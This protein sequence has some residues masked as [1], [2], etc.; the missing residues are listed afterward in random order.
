MGQSD[1]CRVTDAHAFPLLLLPALP[2]SVRR[3]DQG[4]GAF[5]GVQ[6]TD[7]L[8]TVRNTLTKPYQQLR[9]KL[10]LSYAGVTVLALLTVEVLL[11]LIAGIGVTVLLN[12][13]AIPRQLIQ[14]VSVQYT[15]SLRPHL[16][17]SPPDLRGI[18]DVL[19]RADAATTITIPLSF[20]IREF[21]VIGADQSLL[22]SSPPDL[23]GENSLGR[24]LEI[25]TVP[26]LADPLEAALAGGENL[27]KLYAV[28][29]PGGTVVIAVPVWDAEHFEVLGALVGLAEIPTAL[30]FLGEAA[31]VVGVSLIFFTAVAGVAG[32]AYGLLA[33]RGPVERLSRLAKAS[34]AWGQG[35]FSVVVEDPAS[36]ELGELARRL[37]QMAN[38]LQQLLDMRQE[39]AA[40]RERNRLARD[41]HD[42]VKQLAFATAAQIG[43]ARTLVRRDP[44]EAT[45]HIEE[46]ERLTHEL[47]QELSSL[48]LELAP[49]ALEDKGLA[50]ALRNYSESWSRQN[51]IEVEMRVQGERALPLKIDQTVFRIAQE[52][53]ANAARHSNAHNMEI[54][55]IYGTD[56]IRCVIEDDGVGFNLSDDHDG[57]GLRSMADRA[58]ALEGELT[59]ESETGKGTRVTAS[60]P[61]D[62]SHDDRRGENDG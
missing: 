53:L 22:G 34:K 23:L 49:P 33:A 42:S 27:D 26:E 55:L 16:A 56:T 17:E 29:E 8:M 24:T 6:P 52:A 41:L 20:D 38:Q 32:I 28:G 50:A 13:G 5:G 18:A 11:L 58:N 10:A 1:D 7:R 39:L 43:T 45:A 36:D 9:W 19:A 35:D 12:S 54:D 37:N 14:E 3:P 21:L 2:A 61:I 25:E 46:A 47:R 4:G 59:V 57:F 31:P 51:N 40:L 60:L 48:I 62:D 30:N 15:P 44:A